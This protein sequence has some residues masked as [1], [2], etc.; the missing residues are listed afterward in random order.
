M[1]KFIKG[2]KIFTTKFAENQKL[3]HDL[4]ENGQHPKVL[5]VGCSDSRVVPEFIVNANA[6][7]LFVMRNIANII[8][9]KTAN[10][11]CT[12]SALEYAVL[13]LKV[14][15]IVICGHTGCGGIDT[16]LKG[17]PQDSTI[18]DWLQYA[19]SAVKNCDENDDLLLATIKQ[20]ILTQVTHLLTF[21][22]VQNRLEKLKIHKWL[23]DMNSGEISFFDDNSQDWKMFDYSK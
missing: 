7:D 8:P 23:Y 18:A 16:L 13:H 9:P 14:E 11:S 22:F 15:H 12:S 10:E 6:G 4:V 20:N 19:C 5:W 21:G 3:Y 1:N 17:V 2:N